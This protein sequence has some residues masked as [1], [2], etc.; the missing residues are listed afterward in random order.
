MNPLPKATS[1]LV[2]TLRKLQL[3]K[4]PVRRQELLELGRDALL[5]W[6]GMGA[7][8]LLSGTIPVTKPT[9]TLIQRNADHLKIIADPKADEE[10][11]KTAI[12]KR[13]GAGFLGGVIIRSLLQWAGRLKKQTAPKKK[14]A[15]VATH[16]P[17]Q[18]KKK[19]A[20]P[21]KKAASPKKKNAPLIVKLN[22]KQ[23]REANAKSQATPNVSL[24]AT[25][26]RR[27][28]PSPSP[29]RTTASI[30]KSIYG[31]PIRFPGK[32]NIKI[33]KRKQP[34]ATKTKAVL[35]ELNR[36]KK[37]S[38]PKQ[39]LLFPLLPKPLTKKDVSVSMNPTTST[40]K[41]VRLPSFVS[42][43]RSLQSSPKPLSYSS[44]Y[45]CPWCG[46]LFKSSQELQSHKKAQH[47]MLI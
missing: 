10:A 15:K 23:I 25:Q 6:F 47:P 8:N 12:L 18:R 5:K 45:K 17:K 11:K 24:P 22:L 7:K 16:P 40:P 27:V 38:S 31:Q 4:D 20:S 2:T 35:K 42:T 39:S 37:K 14:R 13:G 33:T 32:P 9:A 21:K 46:A 19:A 28:V 26:S 36:P 1:K 44:I 34:P 43:F 41:S 30:A 29:P 3:E